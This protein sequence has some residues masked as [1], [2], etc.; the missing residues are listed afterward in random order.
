M[1][2]TV[3]LTGVTGYLGSHLA[4]A[5]LAQGNHVIGL[6]RR[7]SSLHR[8]DAVLPDLVLYDL[9][10]LDFKVP[11]TAHGRVD[12]VIH[13]ATCYGRND[14]SVSQIVEVNTVYPLKLLETALTVG[15]PAFLNADT[16][17]NKYLNAYALS[18]KQFTEWGSY[19][20]NAGKIRFLNARLEHFYGPG[21]D[22][23]KFTS[24]VIQSCLANVPEL[25]LTLGEQKRDFIYIDDAVDALLRVLGKS[26]SLTGM[27]IEFDV[28]SGEA[29]S[30]REFVETVHRL[31]HATTQLYFGALPYRKGEVKMAQAN[32]SFLNHIGWYPKHTLTKGIELTMSKTR[33]V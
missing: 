1:N 19:F 25:K 22:A 33:N 16:S 23:S 9:E 30:I 11:F 21:D 3:L 2:R 6:K 28:G 12:V 13:T 17:L 8:I 15:V 5:L 7:N 10:G 4:N 18:K 29:V 32:I 26:D 20:A 14:E 24:H 27:F 31:A